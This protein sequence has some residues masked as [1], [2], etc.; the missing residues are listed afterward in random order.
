L[1]ITLFDNGQPHCRLT[2]PPRGTPANI[3]I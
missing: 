2:R 1:K 3:R